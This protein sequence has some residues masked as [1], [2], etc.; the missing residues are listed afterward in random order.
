VP[1][2]FDLKQ[3]LNHAA[4][5]DEPKKCKANVSAELG[6]TISSPEPTMLAEIIRPGPSC[7]VIPKKVSG[8]FL[9]SVIFFESRTVTAGSDL[10]AAKS[11]RSIV[12]SDCYK[13][14]SI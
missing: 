12:K 3:H 9:Y 14:V 1:A 11:A 5:N 10:P 7:F 13:A 4:E 8:G 6:V 2:Q